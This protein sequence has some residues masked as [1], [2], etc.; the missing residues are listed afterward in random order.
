MYDIYLTEVN[1][2]GQR[3]PAINH[4]FTEKIYTH[5]IWCLK[6]LNACLRVT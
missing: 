6:S 2:V 5:A 1:T 3:I 4:T